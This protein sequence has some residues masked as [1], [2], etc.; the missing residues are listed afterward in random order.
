MHVTGCSW[1]AKPRCELEGLQTGP[2]VC[3]FLCQ[4]QLARLN[5][6]LQQQGLFLAEMQRPTVKHA[7]A[8]MEDVQGG[9]A[10]SN[11]AA[12]R[13]AP[14]QS[15]PHIPSRCLSAVEA[16]RSCSVKASVFGTCPCMSCL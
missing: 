7:A 2:P 12:Q 14:L 10:L 6:R 11:G 13:A 5:A 3:N 16:A 4:V 15:L 9:Q 1:P 8:P